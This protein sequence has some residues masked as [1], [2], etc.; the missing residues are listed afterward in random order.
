MVLGLRKR[1]C[2]QGLRC[3]GQSARTVR[4]IAAPTH[5]CPFLK[6]A[7]PAE[8]EPA[9]HSVYTQ[10]PHKVLED[11]VDR[12]IAAEEASKADEEVDRLRQPRTRGCSHVR[13]EPRPWTPLEQLEM[14]VL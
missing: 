14:L 7:R 5:T 3:G 9:Q 12:W 11:I 8:P 6:E 10:D 13:G 2:L 1:R 4:A